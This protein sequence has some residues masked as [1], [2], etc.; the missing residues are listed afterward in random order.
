MSKIDELTTNVEKWRI[1]DISDYWLRV[2][3]IGS[4]LNRFGDHVLSMSGGTLYHQWDGNWR[5][6]ERGSDFWLFSVP[7]SFAWARDMLLKV[8]PTDRRVHEDTVQIQFDS[9]YGYVKLLRVSIGERAVSNFTFEV[10]GFGVGK[11]PA[12]D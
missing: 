9:T 11:H 4:E 3:Y 12:L 2:G 1:S 10:K 5:T 8:V 6:I 7:G